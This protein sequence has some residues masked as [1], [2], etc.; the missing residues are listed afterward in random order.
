MCVYMYTCVLIVVDAHVDVPVSSLAEEPE[1]PSKTAN[2][3]TQDLFR[4][5]GS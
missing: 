3:G 1:Q 2:R 5:C 4:L